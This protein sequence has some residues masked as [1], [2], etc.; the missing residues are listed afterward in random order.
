MKAGS[1][2]KKCIQYRTNG[3]TYGLKVI[4]GANPVKLVFQVSGKSL[5]G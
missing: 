5:K 2:N 3:E 4:R 1:S